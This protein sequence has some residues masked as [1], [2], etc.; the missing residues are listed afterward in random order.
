MF[1]KINSKYTLYKG[2]SNNKYVE[3]ILFNIRFVHQI[4]H[5]Y[6]HHFLLSLSSL[7]LPKNLLIIGLFSQ[8]TRAPTPMVWTNFIQSYPSSKLLYT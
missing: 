8:I 4:S 3:I 7:D 5:L 2:L 1:N 6:L